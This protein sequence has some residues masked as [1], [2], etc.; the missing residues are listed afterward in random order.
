MAL[1]A[2]LGSLFIINAEMDAAAAATYN[3]TNPVGVA[4]QNTGD[5]AFEVVMISIQW[6][7]VDSAVTASGQLANMR[8]LGTSTVQ[9]ANVDAAGVATNMF[10][11]AIECTTSAGAANVVFAVPDNSVATSAVFSGA[12][13]L[14][15]VTVDAQTQ[16][17][18]RFY[19]RA[20]IQTSLTVT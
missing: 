13:Q 6:V 7:A 14:R 19:C 4:Q 17:K 18:I 12:D 9:I 15:I 16:I 10:A 11:S 3:M 20:G 1:T 8:G 2:E 5:T